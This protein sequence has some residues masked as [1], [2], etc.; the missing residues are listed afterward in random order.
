MKLI[1]KAV[2]LG[3][4]Q[5]TG[6][7]GKVYSNVNLDFDGDLQTL[8]VRSLEPFL[9]LKKYNVYDFELSYAAYQNN[10]VSRSY[11]SLDGVVGA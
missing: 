1:G 5:R 11:L 7:D 4:V 3:Y 2:Y 6:K 8:G 9:A 10:G